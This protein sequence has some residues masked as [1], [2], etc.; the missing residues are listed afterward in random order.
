MNDIQ[1]VLNL[2]LSITEVAKCW[3]APRFMP[4]QGDG[5][6]LSTSLT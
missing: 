6:T 3:A 4:A 5:L 1:G 2:L